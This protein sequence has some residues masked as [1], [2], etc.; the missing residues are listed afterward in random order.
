ME[1]GKQD[2]VNVGDEKEMDFTQGLR[3]GGYVH[4]QG[5]GGIQKWVKSMRRGA[6]KHTQSL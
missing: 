4:W 1:L 3:R 2:I 6:E 5:S